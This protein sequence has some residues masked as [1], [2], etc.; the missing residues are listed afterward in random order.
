MTKYKLGSEI[1]G[2]TYDTLLK[3]YPSLAEL[4]FISKETFSTNPD[5]PDETED[6]LVLT[7]SDAEEIITLDKTIRKDM[8]EEVLRDKYMGFYYEPF[9]E[10]ERKYERYPDIILT[11]RL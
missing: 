8:T 11:Y 1:C 9:D 4:P 6:Y 5:D 3:Y 2:Y 10:E 7:I